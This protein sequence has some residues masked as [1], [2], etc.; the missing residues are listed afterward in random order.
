MGLCSISP[1]LCNLSIKSFW[2][3]DGRF[4]NIDPYFLFLKFSHSDNILGVIERISTVGVVDVRNRGLRRREENER[5]TRKVLGDGQSNAQIG[6][7]LEYIHS[8]GVLFWSVR[9]VNRSGKR[10]E[11]F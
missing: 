7:F 2:K 10:Q 1:Y 8:L 9:I 4:R 11:E 6:S 3:N 5:Q